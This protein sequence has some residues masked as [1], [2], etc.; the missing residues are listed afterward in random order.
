[1]D[2]SSLSGEG[3]G[4][5]TFCRLNSEVVE[6]PSSSNAGR[7]EYLVVPSPPPSDQ[8]PGSPA[9]SKAG[10]E[11]GESWWPIVSSWGRY[12]Q[13][14]G[15]VAVSSADNLLAI[16]LCPTGIMSD[17]EF[18]E[19]GEVDEGFDEEFE[20]KDLNEPDN[21]QRLHQE[22]PSYQMEELDPKELQQLLG[23]EPDLA[24]L[25]DFDLG[26][27]VML[28][29]DQ[30][31]SIMAPLCSNSPIYHADIPAPMGLL[32]PSPLPSIDVDVNAQTV[33][34]DRWKNRECGA[35]QTLSPVKSC[36]S[37][38]GGCSADK[39]M[40]YSEEQLALCISECGLVLDHEPYDHTNLMD[41][42]D[43]FEF[44]MA[45]SSSTDLLLFGNGSGH[46]NLLP[47]DTTLAENDAS[48]SSVGHRNNMAD[49]AIC[50]TLDLPL[51]SVHADTELCESLYPHPSPAAIPLPLSTIPTGS[52]SS[53]LPEQDT[54]S[55]EEQ[56]LID[57]LY[58]QFR[59]LLDDPSISENMKEEMKS[60]RRKGK[61]KA[62]AKAC[63]QKKV[64][65][66]K[67]LEQEIEQLRRTKLQIVLRTEAFER[68][69]AELKRHC[70][71]LS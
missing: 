25:E 5:P 16:S 4:S 1:M 52:P 3:E 51:S 56:R 54:F 40:Q 21:N 49:L 22:H 66:V 65:K 57:M 46:L 29:N 55:C 53:P 69:I 9:H 62:A 26:V 32:P 60:I 27:D 48:T 19:P 37:T 42:T 34:V 64:H 45:D 18:E 33:P 2:K 71:E 13:G 28:D 14:G 50:P 35:S 31:H 68:E 7:H 63:R 36:D 17:G 20:E 70:Q 44:A 11:V 38:T 43:T 23:M 24:G 30:E 67:G 59:K 39:T 47:S 15:D 10:S 61:N 6:K 12:E 8:D 58:Y 41:L